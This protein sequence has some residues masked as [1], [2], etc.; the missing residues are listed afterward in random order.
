MTIIILDPIR[1]LVLVVVLLIRMKC[2][3][4]FVG[5]INRSRRF[6]CN[7]SIAIKN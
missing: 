5:N 1:I 6:L 2:L 7:D 4:H 3:S